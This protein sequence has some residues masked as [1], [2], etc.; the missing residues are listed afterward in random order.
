MVDHHR[1][2]VPADIVI[3]DEVFQVGHERL[4]VR[5]P[6][7]Q[8][9]LADATGRRFVA[10]EIRR[11]VTRH[12]RRDGRFNAADINDA[13]LRNR[14]YLELADIR[15]GTAERWLRENHPNVQ[16]TDWQRNYIVAGNP[17]DLHAPPRWVANPDRVQTFEEWARNAQDPAAATGGAIP[18]FRG[19][20]A[21]TRVNMPDGGGWVN[22][23]TP[24]EPIRID[25]ADNVRVQIDENVRPQPRL[26]RLMA[27]TPPWEAEPFDEADR[28]L[29][30]MARRHRERVEAKQKEIKVEKPR[31]ACGEDILP[32]GDANPAWE[33]G[34]DECT[35]IERPVDQYVDHGA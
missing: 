27:T 28:A 2:G 3:I 8:R 17:D 29:A 22:I 1:Q 7:A 30:D 35:Y 33:H 12:A 24:V 6:V 5:L 25:I 31:C 19:N 15:P 23:R 9:L 10:E 34:P 26:E 20:Y 32:D 18:A 16:L 21:T 14:R 4:A 13:V 11:E